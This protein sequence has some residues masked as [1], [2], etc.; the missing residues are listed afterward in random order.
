MGR[1][2]QT[3][4]TPERLHLQRIRFVDY[5][6]DAGGAYWGGDSPLYCAFSPATTQN[7]TPIMVFVRAGSR[8][9]AKQKV[10][11]E[12]PGKGWGFVR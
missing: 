7:A 1:R 10:L 3:E 4:G 5:D 12:L 11:A 6:Y 9:E 2:N 8:H